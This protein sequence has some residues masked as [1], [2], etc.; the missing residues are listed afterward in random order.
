MRRVRG[1]GRVEVRLGR[2]ARAGVQGGL[3]YPGDQEGGRVPR[4]GG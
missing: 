4:V 3:F 2:A 1:D